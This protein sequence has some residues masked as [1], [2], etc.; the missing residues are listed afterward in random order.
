MKG[1]DWKYVL[2]MVF[3]IITS[4]IATFFIHEKVRYNKDLLGLVANIFSILTGFLLLVITSSGDAASFTEGK[5][6]SEKYAIK[7]KFEI[8]F[9]RYMMLFYLYLT[10]LC[11]IFFYYM[12]LPSGDASKLTSTKPTTIG[13]V[14]EFVICWLSIISFGCSFFIPIKLKQIYSEKLK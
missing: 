9:S 10:V 8:R 1:K 14:L 6:R 13:L 7:R 2:I 3:F 12:L 4:L 11:L 5:S